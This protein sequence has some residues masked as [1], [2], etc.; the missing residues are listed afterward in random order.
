MVKVRYKEGHGRLQAD[1]SEKTEKKW[2]KRATGRDR[3]IAVWLSWLRE[4]GSLFGR[5]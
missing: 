3:V 2:R 5:Q 1:F 4:S